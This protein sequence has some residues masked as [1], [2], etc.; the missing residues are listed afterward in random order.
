MDLFYAYANAINHLK[1]PKLLPDFLQ[2]FDF[3]TIDILY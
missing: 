3:E 2:L 1:I